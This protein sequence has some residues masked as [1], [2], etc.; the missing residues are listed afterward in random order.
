MFRLRI[1]RQQFR[2]R[3]WEP[4]R[5]MLT[6][7]LMVCNLSFWVALLLGVSLLRGLPIASWRKACRRL[8]ERLPIYWIDGNI[9]IQSLTL[10]N[11]RPQ[12]WTKVEDLGDQLNVQS[13]YLLIA[14][15]RSWTDILVLQQVFN[16]RIPPLKFFLKRQLLW[17][18]PIA[19]WACWLLD[20]P[21]VHRYTRN[22]LRRRPALKN[23]NLDSA[24]QV[25]EQYRYMPTTV[26]N[27]VEGTRFTLLKHQEQQ[28]PYQYLLRPQAGG[29]ALSLAALGHY[30]NSVLDVTLIY[31]SR[32]INLWHFL[33]GRIQGINLYVEALPI[34]TDLLG[35][36][37][38]DRVFR[39]AFQKWLGQLWQR[40][41]RLVQTSTVAPV[42]GWQLLPLYQQGRGV[43]CFPLWLKEIKGMNQKFWVS[44]AIAIGIVL[45]MV[46]NFGGPTYTGIVLRVVRSLEILLP[47]LATAALMKYLIGRK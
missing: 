35:D 46:A 20:F 45:A 10:P 1:F 8:T 16:R 44:I 40:K 42:P 36:Y 30:L 27:F 19:S 43:V 15:H 12:L 18:L 22:Q 23:A 34:T 7:L 39:I 37:R 11:V 29:A 13:W 2:T 25:C 33:C 32:H 4:F 14:N 5:G 24:K 47:V 38:N 17:T 41:D 31:P 6:L 9:L 28:V 3:L 21:F 26:V